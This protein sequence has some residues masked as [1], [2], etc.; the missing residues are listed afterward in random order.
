M[1]LNFTRKIILLLYTISIFVTCVLCLPY[2]YKYDHDIKTEYNPIWFNTGSIDFSRVILEI[3][4]LT[5]FFGLFFLMLGKLKTPDCNNIKVK[6]K[7]IK[8]E[9]L[10]FLGII[11]ITFLFESY[12]NIR[13]YYLE[14]EQDKINNKITENIIKYDSL[15][16]DILNKKKTRISF[17][18]SISKL[19]NLDSS[20]NNVHKFW[21]ELAKNKLFVYNEYLPIPPDVPAL[22]NGL[23]LVP[24]PYISGVKTYDENGIQ[25]KN[26]TS[27]S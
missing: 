10:I 22:P 24:L 23:R 3:F 14:K 1:K 19:Y 13:N 27:L 11:F 6:K 21:E 7:T 2:T 16:K 18:N 9:M 5:C 4:V 20:V 26:Q 25:I 12:L 8:R 15:R 17:F